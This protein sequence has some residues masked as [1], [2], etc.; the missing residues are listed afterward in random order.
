MIL[1]LCPQNSKL[2]NAVGNKNPK[3]M[4]PKPKSVRRVRPEAPEIAKHN[5]ILLTFKQMSHLW[6]RIQASALSQV[7][8]PRVC[9]SMIDAKHSKFESGTWDIGSE[10][11]CEVP[12]SSRYINLI[13]FHIIWILSGINYSRGV[14][15]PGMV[16]SKYPLHTWISCRH[17]IAKLYLAWVCSCGRSAPCYRITDAMR[18]SHIDIHPFRNIFEGDLCAPQ[19]R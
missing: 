19:C 11:G 14:K 4:K 9:G 5:I 15:S 3:A 2:H 12:W 6:C 10:T 13:L 17:E 8:V 1:E 16:Y 18:C 7:L